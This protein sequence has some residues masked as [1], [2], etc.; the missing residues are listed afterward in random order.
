MSEQEGEEVLNNISYY[1]SG[2]GIHWC[3]ACNNVVI[4]NNLGFGNRTGGIV[5]G[6]GDAPGGVTTDNSIVSN[7][8]AVN[9]SGY[10]IREYG[11]TGRKNK[12][13]N[14]LVYGN[15]AGGFSLQHGIT[16]I[17]TV[18]ANPHSIF[19]NFQPN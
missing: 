10:G 2:Y 7:N 5:I 17:N 19:V 3:H 6:A 4:A 11:L 13:Y 18:I 8:I 15:S 14:N 9:N 12:C 1:N 16:D